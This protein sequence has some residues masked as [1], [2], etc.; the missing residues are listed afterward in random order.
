MAQQPVP[1]QAL[2]SALRKGLAVCNDKLPSLEYLEKLAL[3]NPAIQDAV[4]ELRI[5]HEA[6]N[7]ICR[8]GLLQDIQEQTDTSE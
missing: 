1:S 5:K 8:A 4:D 7:K 3:S 2:L 6:L